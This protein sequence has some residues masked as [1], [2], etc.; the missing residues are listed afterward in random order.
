MIEFHQKFFF[1]HF[2]FPHKIYFFKIIKSNKSS[3]LQT[4]ENK[5]K[6]L[7]Y[8]FHKHDKIF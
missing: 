6:T 1:T 8:T 7:L 2:Y 5:I 3:I 4:Q